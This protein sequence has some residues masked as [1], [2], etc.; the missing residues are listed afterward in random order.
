MVGVG[1]KTFVS[2]VYVVLSREILGTLVNDFF[3]FWPLCS[4]ETEEMC[5]AIGKIY[6]LVVCNLGSDHANVV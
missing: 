3:S 4:R 1:G 2:M 5:D 6:T